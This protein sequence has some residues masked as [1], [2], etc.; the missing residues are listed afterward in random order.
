MKGTSTMNQWRPM[1]TKQATMSH[2]FTKGVIV[3]SELSSEIALKALSI[4]MT[5]RTERDSVD[6]LT[7]P[8]VKYLHGLS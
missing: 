1:D 3:R 5:T 4:S 6:A 7:L 2:K 8:S